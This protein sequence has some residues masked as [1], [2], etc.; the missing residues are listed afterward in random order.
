M[1]CKW[2]VI[3]D[4]YLIKGEKQANEALGYQEQNHS[5]RL[6]PVERRFPELGI[7]GSDQLVE[8]IGRKVEVLK[9][10]K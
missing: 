9:G 6:R 5:S 1:Q 3:R 8:K 4:K 2:V 7:W 10:G